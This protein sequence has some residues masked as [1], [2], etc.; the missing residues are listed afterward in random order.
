MIA[1][2]LGVRSGR[3]D[4]SFWLR[5]SPVRIQRGLSAMFFDPFFYHTVRDRQHAIHQRRE[6][7]VLG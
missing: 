1:V 7:L 4:L 3:C 2:Y 6:A 5:P